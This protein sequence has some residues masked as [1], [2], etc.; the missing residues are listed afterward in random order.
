MRDV[1]GWIEVFDLERTEILIKVG[2]T[3][4]FGSGVEC[5]YVIPGAEVPEQWFRIFMEGNLIMFQNISGDPLTVNGKL[6]EKTNKIIFLNGGFISIPGCE[7]TF[8]VYNL[9]L[10]D[11]IVP[12]NSP[13][14]KMVGLINI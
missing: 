11:H 8:R 6:M 2:Q 1:A 3:F 14:Y 4:I 5:D 9:E 12:D 13:D 10:T 7:I